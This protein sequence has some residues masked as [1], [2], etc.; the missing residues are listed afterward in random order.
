MKLSA[1]PLSIFGYGALFLV[2]LMAA[3]TIVDIWGSGFSEEITTN[4][5]GTFA[6]AM[7]LL[8]AVAGAVSFAREQAENKKNNLVR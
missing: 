6:V 5:W 7:V 4:I 8:G 1:I 3:F 2:F